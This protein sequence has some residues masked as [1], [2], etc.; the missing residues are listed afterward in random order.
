MATVAR[1][2]GMDVSRLLDTAMIRR[3][4]LWRL[5]TSI[6]PH[7]DILH[8]AFNIYWLWVFGTLLE[9][10][11]GPIKTAGLILLFAVGS[12]ALEFA[13]L[14]GGIGLSGVGYGLFGLLWV[15]SS[16]DERFKDA[17]DGRTI[18]LFVVWFFF[19]IAATVTNILPVANIA[20][21]A[22]GVF[23]IL[24]GFAIARRDRRV[25]IAAGIA[26]LLVMSLCAATIW[27]PAINMSKSAGYEEGRWGY[28]ALQAHRDEEAVRWF[29]D[30]VRYQPK[31]SAYWFDLGIAYERLKDEPAAIHAYRTAADLGNASAQYY[32]GQLYLD[33]GA[34]LPKDN[35]Q[36]LS[37]FRKATAQDNPAAL[38]DI[39]WLCATSTNPAIRNPTAALEYAR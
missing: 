14:A 31:V 8:L 37:W 11:L 5:V 35:A 21:G 24:A 23:G 32:L 13:F 34:G 15:L 22:G 29:R 30:A 36:A 19:C 9:L 18:Q 27:R 1:W 10:V 17:I 3:G 25:L 6:L 12:G 33:G 16:R 39:A 4:E 2:A 7:A 20:H 28:D 26:G 38:N